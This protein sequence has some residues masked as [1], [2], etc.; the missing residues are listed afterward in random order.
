MLAKKNVALNDE[1]SPFS[2]LLV[3]VYTFEYLLQEM[4]FINMLNIRYLTLHEY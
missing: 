2:D 1:K 3:K 4:H